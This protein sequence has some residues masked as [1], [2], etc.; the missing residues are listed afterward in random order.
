MSQCNAF[1]PRKKELIRVILALAKKLFT[2]IVI[3][4]L[5]VRYEHNQLN[6]IRD[7]IVR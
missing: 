5:Q 1:E 6:K 4:L 7:E 3:S 2:Y